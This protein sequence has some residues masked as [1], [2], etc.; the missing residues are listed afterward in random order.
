[1]RTRSKQ[2]LIRM[3]EKEYR[4][5]QNRLMLSGK[6]GNEFCIDCL[7]NRTITVIPHTKEILLQLKAIGNNLNQIAHAANAGFQVPP[8]ITEIRQ[9]V[10]CLW[11]LLKP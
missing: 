3:D 11:Q 2:I 6:N 8:I 10:N 5:Y 7:L 1:M 9:E 4:K